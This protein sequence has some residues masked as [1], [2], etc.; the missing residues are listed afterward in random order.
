MQD[1][2]VQYYVTFSLSQEPEILVTLSGDQVPSDP[3]VLPPHRDG[4]AIGILDAVLD[5]SAPGG[6]AAVARPHHEESP[7]RGPWLLLA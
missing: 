6:D 4:H 2:L 7:R 3:P 5:E 1:G